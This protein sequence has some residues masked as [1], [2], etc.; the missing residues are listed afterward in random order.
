M[1]LKVKKIV[2]LFFIL[3]IASSEC[4]GKSS[5]KPK[6]TKL[7]YED[8]KEL[9]LITLGASIED[10]VLHSCIKNAIKTGKAVAIK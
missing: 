8:A 4:F 7:N 6:K 10:N 2:L 5:K 1:E 9:C 3:A